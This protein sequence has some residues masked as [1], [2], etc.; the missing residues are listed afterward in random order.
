MFDFFVQSSNKLNPDR[1]RVV[2]RNADVRM[3]AAILRDMG[4]VGVIVGSRRSR[5]SRMVRGVASRHRREEERERGGGGERERERESERV[6]ER[7]RERE[8][9]IRYVFLG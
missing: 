5:G 1:V 6:R 8:R 3:R 4:G 7:E 2:R 9:E